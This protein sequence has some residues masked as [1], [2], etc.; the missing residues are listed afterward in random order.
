MYGIWLR[1]QCKCRHSF[2]CTLTSLPTPT[3]LP[4]LHPEGK[5]RGKI[6]HSSYFSVKKKSPFMFLILRW[7]QARSHPDYGDTNCPIST[8]ERKAILKHFWDFPGGLVVKALP[9]QCKG[10]GFNPWSRNEDPIC[11]MTKQI[12]L[13][14]ITNLIISLGQYNLI[15]LEIF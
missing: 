12:P 10:C 8:V 6:N 2:L 5:L 3:S 15:T 9:F 13:L 7:V 14:S 1:D 11:C 4:T